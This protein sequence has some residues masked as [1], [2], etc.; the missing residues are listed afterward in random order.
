LVD[1]NAKFYLL[2][3]LNNDSLHYN[4]I[5]KVT[6]YID[7]LFSFGLLQTITKPTRCTE[8]SATLIDHVL[9]NCLSETY[10]S[11]ILTTRISDHFPIVFYL[12]VNKFKDSPKFFETRD[13]SKTK[14]DNFKNALSNFNWSTVL[15]TQDVQESYNIFSDTFFN[16]YQLYFP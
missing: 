6:E 9:T 2:G 1:D 7:I 5:T 4:K 13:L 15:N 8:K 12:P 3:D 11:V 14:I 10:K 16:L